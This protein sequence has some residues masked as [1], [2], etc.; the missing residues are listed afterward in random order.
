[1]FRPVRICLAASSFAAILCTPAQ[2]DTKAGV[3]AWT[4]GDYAAAVREWTAEADRGDADAL[5]NL[6]Q[7]SRLGQGAPSDLSKAEVYYGRAAAL[8]HLQAADNYGLLLFQR[9]EQTR[10]LPYLVAA[11]GRGEPRAQYLLGVAHFNGTLV[12][13]DW[14]RA[15]ALVSLSS[16][17]GVVP[18]AAA[19]KQMD[20]FIPL[21]ERQKGVQMSA[22]I[23]AESSA[24]RAQQLAA[25]DLGAK[26]PV[27]V[28]ARPTAAQPVPEKSSPST[29]G[30]DFAR[31]AVKA[32][33]VASVPKPALPAP[34]PKSAAPI[35]PRDKPAPA[36]AWR[37]QL[38]AFSQAA[39]ADALWNRVKSQPA[40][41]GHPRINVSAGGVTRLQAGGFASAVDAKAACATLAKAGTTCIPLP[42]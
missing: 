27:V 2:A 32:T 10:A 40:L 23:E 36:G 33:F 39:N 17:Q 8:G 11:A 37:I 42:N 1:M 21:D 6:G 16:Q 24:A 22:A 26:V 30:A 35:E 3:D 9:G 4:R 7:A 28:P 25:V 15:Y 5:Y 12:A 14:P 18:A 13:R 20:T 41:S 19:L 31:P 38:G 29:A 34:A